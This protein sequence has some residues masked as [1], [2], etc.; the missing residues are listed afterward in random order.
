MVTVCIMVVI[1]YEVEVSVKDLISCCVVVETWVVNLVTV[2]ADAV[3]AGGATVTACFRCKG[4]P[5]WRKSSPRGMSESRN[6][7]FVRD[8]FVLP[9]LTSLLLSSLATGVAVTVA[10]TQCTSVWVAAFSMV[11][12]S[13]EKIVEVAT[14]TITTVASWCSVRVLVPYIV[15]MT[16]TAFLPPTQLV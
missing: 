5:L 4:P 10:V 15:E 13:V 8:E 1:T 7:F 11:V 6:D 14:S 9:S 12:S 3:A 16:V 2:D